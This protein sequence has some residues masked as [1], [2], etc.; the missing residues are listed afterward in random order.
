CRELKRHIAPYAG[1]G[2][3]DICVGNG[4]VEIIHL[5]AGLFARRRVVIPAPTFCEYEIAAKRNGAFVEYVPLRGLVLDGDSV[6]ESCKGADAVFLCNPNNP[7]GILSTAE[8]IKVIERVDTSTM[9][10]VDECFIELCNRPQDTLVRR[11]A[12]FDNL[13]VL[14][15]LTKSFA[16]AGL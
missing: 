10:M 1:C 11:V 8:V 5:F 14:R 16:L 9:V 3:S 6:V 2:E 4:A 15:S 12:E 7:T 13:V